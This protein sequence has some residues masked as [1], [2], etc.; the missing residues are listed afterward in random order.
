M[1][2]TPKHLPIGHFRQRRAKT[3]YTFSQGVFWKTPAI[4]DFDKNPFYDSANIVE[5]IK[6]VSASKTADD[7]YDFDGYSSETVLAD[8]IKVVDSVSALRFCNSYG[9]PC[10]CDGIFIDERPVAYAYFEGNDI[11]NIL[12]EAYTL[13]ICQIIV[14]AYSKDDEKAQAEY[15]ENK[16][17]TK[18]TPLFGDDNLFTF[19]EIATKRETEF[20]GV[21]GFGFSNNVALDGAMQF[22]RKI[23]EK[24]MRA[25]GATLTLLPR[26]RGQG[27]KMRL[28]AFV[29]PDDLLGVMWHRFTDGAGTRETIVECEI[30]GQ[31]F[32][33]LRADARKCSD[34]CRQRSHRNGTST[35]RKK[36]AASTQ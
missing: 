22:L 32:R 20:V 5:V 33:A 36:R 19:C 7:Y 2:R 6:P 9:L 35:P 23:V 28:Q 25:S 29:V 30:C 10:R 15:F 26:Q 16:F 31:W 11:S 14:N 27:S 12:N 3:G 13:R 1:P 4:E 18:I 34:K 21:I 24:K 8:F 17:E